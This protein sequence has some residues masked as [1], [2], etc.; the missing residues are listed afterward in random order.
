[1][2]MS[3]LNSSEEY[4]GIKCTVSSNLRQSNW[5]LLLFS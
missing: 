4:H 1:V 2:S 3:I 5:Y